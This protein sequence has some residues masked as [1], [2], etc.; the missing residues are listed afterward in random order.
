MPDC[1]VILAAEDAAG[2]IASFDERLAQ[3][4]EK[5]NLSVVRG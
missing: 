4:A 3:T 5:R 1:C 2:A